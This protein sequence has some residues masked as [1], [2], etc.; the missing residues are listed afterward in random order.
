ML[1]VKIVQ[2]QVG[3]LFKTML[4]TMLIDRSDFKAEEVNACF[5]FVICH[6]ACGHIHQSHRS[7]LLCVVI[8][9]LPVF[10]L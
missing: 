6:K 7:R 5:V 9:S 2:K 4:I 8:Y 1:W 3:F 10:S